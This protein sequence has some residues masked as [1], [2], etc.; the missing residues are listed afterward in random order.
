[1]AAGSSP[2][3][4]LL[5]FAVFELDLQSGELRKSGR[6]VILPPQPFK[7]LALL[8]SRQGELVTREEIQREVWGN[9]AFVDFERGLNFAISK[10]RTALADNP[11]TPRYVE[12]LP[13]RGY[14]FLYP[15]EHVDV[16]DNRRTEQVKA[17]DAAPVAAAAP[18]AVVTPGA[19]RRVFIMTLSAAALIGTG[20]ALARLIL[21]APAAPPQWSGVLL[22]G[23]DMALNPRLSPDGHLLAIQA[24]VDGL[25]QVAVMKPES[26]NW[27]VLTRRRDRGAVTFMCWSPDGALIYF[28]RVTDVPLGIYS[29]PVLGGEEHLVLENADQPAA[30]ADGTI[31]VARRDGQQRTKL[32][33]FFPETGKLQDL[34]VLF[35]GLTFLESLM[36]VRDGKHALAWGRT[37]EGIQQKPGFLE[38]DLFTASARRLPDPG[39]EVRAWAPSRDGKSV[40]IASPAGTLVRFLTMPLDG[41]AAPRT[42]F[43]VS[44]DIRDIDAG[45]DGSLF[46]NLVDRPAEVVRIS[47][48]GGSPEKLASLP[49]L[50]LLDM[51]VALPD[52]RAVVT[53]Q[54]GGR[55]RLM[56][57][58]KG[59]DPSPLLNTTEETTAPITVAGPHAIA[60]AIGP[61]P[62]Q[63]IAIADTSN[64][65]ISGRIAPGKGELT[66][67][68]A[69]P[70]GKTI[71][72]AAGQTIWSVPA[73]GGAPRKI[74]AGADVL[75]DPSGPGLVIAR[76][77]S[78]RITLSRMTLEGGSEQQI[79]TGGEV[80][81][82]ALYQSPGAIRPDGRMLVS[83][84]P[85]DSWFN[86][87]GLLDMATGRVTRLLDNGLNDYH[88]LAWMPDGQI[89]ATRQGLRSTIWKFTPEGK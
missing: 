6:I 5:R 50:P 57:V 42:L 54:A 82:L 34:P 32:F 18:R 33:R 88:T 83:L 62:H 25:T 79:P 76:L 49:Q 29:V 44:H 38:V 56:A 23:P 55:T 26:G 39:V 61:A 78:S 40:I 84:N 48:R 73:G 51:V 22:G 35:S 67:L 10:I 1:M 46:V 27:S 75:I 72:F 9:T 59:K 80:P 43:T 63:T 86:P 31:L 17:Q 89:V 36:F 13:R 77:E 19:G 65:R 68:A 70:D 3:A 20:F 21:P 15:V 14:R 60:F 8:V 7:V 52:G 71:Y 12:T 16:S 11:D 37:L 45:A 28:S 47:P 66:S 41:R 2:R 85:R 30:L 24:M 4:P 69:T 81:L 74:T 58:E 53:V 64:G 87:P